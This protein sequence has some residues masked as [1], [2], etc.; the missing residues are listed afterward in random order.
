MDWIC[1]MTSQDATR[2]SSRERLLDATV[3]LV[4]TK[5]PAASGTKEILARADAPRGSFYFHFPAGKDQLVAAAVARAAA[6]TAA[7]LAAALEDRSRALPERIAGFIEAVGVALAADDYR[8]GCAV[9]A[10]VLETSATSPALRR[11]T[12]TAFAS[13]AAALTEHLA[14]AGLAPDRAAALADCVIAGLEGATLLARARRDTAPLEHVAAMLGA[15]LAA[16]LPLPSA[17]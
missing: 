16:E 6:A 14:G 17:R 13:W 4:R 5:G 7:A 3:E 11:A 1:G 9:A 2:P 12:E 8:L 10:T 15:V